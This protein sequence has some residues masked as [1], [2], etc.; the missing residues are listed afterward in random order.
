MFDDLFSIPHTN[1]FP[2]DEKTP[3]GICRIT[4]QIRPVRI[5]Q[6][7]GVELL[8]SL[9]SVFNLLTGALQCRG[10]LRQDFLLQTA[11]TSLEEQL[12]RQI[13]RQTKV[14]HDGL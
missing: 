5:T 4:H 8:Q 10:L 1:Q 11:F 14:A 12:G 2:L 13:L 3:H 9:E 6:L 7:A